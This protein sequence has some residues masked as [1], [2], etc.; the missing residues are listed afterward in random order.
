MQKQ[1][2]KEKVMQTT[3][4]QRGVLQR[5]RAHVHD[6]LQSSSKLWHAQM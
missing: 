3:P 6:G 1:M 2:P 4:V 5:R